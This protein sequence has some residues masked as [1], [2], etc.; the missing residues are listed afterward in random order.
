VRVVPNQ[1]VSDRELAESIGEKC[2]ILLG[3]F[4]ELACLLQLLGVVI[5]L[6]QGSAAVG[7]FAKGRSREQ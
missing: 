3:C 2:V 1:S 7:L 5:V 6:L 4:V